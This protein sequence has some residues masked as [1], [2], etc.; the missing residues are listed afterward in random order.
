MTTKRT[1]TET[2]Y[3]ALARSY[4]DETVRADEVR[5]IEIGPA[6][7]MGRPTKDV[8]SDGKTPSMT[9]RLPKPIR[10]EVDLRVQAGAV[11]SA[12]DLVR[13]AVVEYLERH[14]A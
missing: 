3:E 12:S 10:K 7:R 6:L 4:T 8:E 11:G 9:V 13:I 1:P 2:E 5:S 14:P